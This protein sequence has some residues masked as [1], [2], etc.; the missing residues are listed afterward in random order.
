MNPSEIAETKN[1]AK[2]R[3]SDF[4]WYE[5]PEWNDNNIVLYHYQTRDSGLIE[6]SNGQYIEKQFKQYNDDTVQFQDFN[7][8]TCGWIKAIAVKIH[9]DENEFTEAFL[10]LCDIFE[11]LDDYPLLDE[12][13]YSTREWE[14]VQ[15]SIK[16]AVSFWARNHDELTEV[17]EDKIGYI[18]SQDCEISEDYYPSDEEIEEAY[19]EFL[20]K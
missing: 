4:S 20:N 11:K 17:D 14:S 8:W 19:Q 13:D 3:P 2:N 7:H 18:I 15:R 1:Y 16:E 9:N 10:T 6:E 12:D 5:K